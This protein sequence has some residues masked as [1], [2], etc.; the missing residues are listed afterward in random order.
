MAGNVSRKLLL[1]ADIEEY[2]RTV[3]L[4]RP[5]KKQEGQAAC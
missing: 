4:G 3:K 5:K 1:P 2:L